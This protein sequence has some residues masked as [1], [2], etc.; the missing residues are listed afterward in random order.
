MNKVTSDEINKA[1]QV[2][3]DTVM[4]QFIATGCVDVVEGTTRSNFRTYANSIANIETKK[5]KLRILAQRKKTVPLNTL[6]TSMD[7][8]FKLLGYTEMTGVQKQTAIH[9]RW[10]PAYG[11]Y[12]YCC[13]CGSGKTLAAIYIAHVLQCK[14]L[15]ISSRNAVNDQWT[16]LIRSLYPNLII[17]TR[18]GWFRGEN[19]LT[20]KQRSALEAA[21]VIP[22][23]S[24]FSPQYLASKIDGYKLTAGL[25]IY[26]EVHSLMSSEFIKVLLLP[27]IKVIN[28]ELNELPY[29]VALSATFP[30]SA[31]REGRESMKRLT[32][33]FGSPYRI[34]DTIT[35][36]PVALW[37]YRDHYQTCDKNGKLMTVAESLGNLDSRYK[38]F[39][40]IEAINYFCDKIKDEGR[41]EIC[42]E[43]K[44]IIMTHKIDASIYAGLHAHQLWNCSVLIMRAA[45]EKSIL[46]RKNEG[47]NFLF[48]V[49]SG[50]KDIDE[51][52]GHRVDD[53]RQVL[54]EVSVIV[55]T[56]QRLKEGFSVENITWGICAQFPYSTIQRVQILG[57]IRRNSKN[58]ALNRR[59]RIMYVCSGSVPTTIGIPNYRGAHK[60]LY[61]FKDEAALF[62][63][64][65]YNRT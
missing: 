3:F 7:D 23:V 14:M 60:M 1:D 32:L 56:I 55:G 52:V 4:T 63:L 20:N 47:L 17:E 58:E 59:P 46:L 37:D 34:E 18:E 41:I 61:N 44:G 50:L 43:F 19:K 54:N 48:N 28:H 29:M 9:A 49:C 26:D 24:V 21:E 25:I 8:P 39:E 11:N 53:Y 13:S 15:V 38:P 57:R 22:D 10:L 36:I 2:R 5:A 30:S 51:T 12:A 64:E 27:L 45:G 33:I 16:M 6:T 31:T 40:E 62:K 65:N 35:R 42:P